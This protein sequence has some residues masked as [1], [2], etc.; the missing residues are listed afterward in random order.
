MSSLQKIAAEIKK[1]DQELSLCTRCGMCQSV[2]P[3]YSETGREYDSAR[4]KFA[5][6]DGLGR[7]MLSDPDGV[8]K[9]LQ[10]CLLCGACAS[11]C[12]RK[13]N[14]LSIFLR[15]RMIIT[16]ITGLN[17][18]K[19]AVLKVV[20]GNPVFFDRLVDA[21]SLV[22]K[23]FSSDIEGNEDYLGIRDGFRSKK[24]IAKK[25]AEKSF[26]EIA[27][28]VDYSVP[29]S[30]GRVLFYPGCLVNRMYPE[31]GTASLDAIIS[32]G[33]DVYVPDGLVCCGMPAAGSGD[34]RSASLAVKINE[35]I[36]LSGKYDYIVTSC[37][38]CAFAIKKL[39]PLF[40]VENKT[41]VSSGMN[42]AH[43]IQKITEKIIDISQFIS[44]SLP[45][46]A[47]S[48]SAPSGSILSDNVSSGSVIACSVSSSSIRKGNT[49]TIHDPCHL[50]RSMGIFREPR[51]LI[52][53]T[54]Y[55]ISE[56]K[57]SDRCCGMGGTFSISHYD[58][59]MSV[60]DS[61]IRSIINTEAGIVAAG[62]PACMMQIGAGL[63]AA[64]A[65]VKIKH[66]VEIF[67][68]NIPVIFRK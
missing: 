44:M 38:T 14:S 15:A 9:L 53:M 41:G 13:I 23:K 29:D 46:S 31:V 50:K 39:W 54:G 6:I 20:C 43:E 19:R 55:E 28:R 16:G 8:L 35:G 58:L 24:R 56:M 65:D 7:S 10:R 3:L 4:G 30:R 64:G 26:S 34:M 48:G 27:G 61:K 36:I 49:V 33:Y 66:P 47:V 60:A 12:P 51:Q 68:E 18:F 52:E 2:C 5:L 45:D 21:A 59:S 57:N 63:A 17:P 62:C 32:C 25:I 37:P 11:H 22:Q 40:A 67:A 1:L 42:A